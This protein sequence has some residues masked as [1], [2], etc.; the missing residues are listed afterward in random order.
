MKSKWYFSTLLLILFVCFGAFQEKTTI[1]NQEIVLEFIDVSINK[2]K[3]NNTITNVKTKLL[4]AGVSN[5]LIKE[6]KSGTLK[7]SYYSAIH[8]D[9]I[10]E[11]L[12]KDNELAFSQNSENKDKNLPLSDYNFDIYEL[13][14]EVDTSNLNDKYVF[15]IKQISDRFTTNPNIAFFRNLELK[16]HC[17][18]VNSPTLFVCV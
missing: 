14:N 12:A 16:K 3:I 18:L 9:N 7:I 10:K 8:I 11:V 6:T 2:N 13:T 1:P 15:E 17:F 5:I 4:S